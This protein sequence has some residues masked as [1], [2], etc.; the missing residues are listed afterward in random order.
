MNYISP[1]HHYLTVKKWEYD[2]LKLTDGKH[3]HYS[4]QKISFSFSLS[5]SLSLFLILYISH[6]LFLI[7][8]TFSALR[9]SIDDRMTQALIRIF[10]ALP[11]HE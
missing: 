2:I 3:P 10:F 1:L 4:S 8:F 6:F 11:S 5:L 9:F 7:L